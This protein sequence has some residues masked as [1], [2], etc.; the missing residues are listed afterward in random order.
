MKSRE[1]V[2]RAVEFETPGRLPLSFDSLGESDFHT[3]QWNQIGT[4]DNTKRRTYDEWGCGWI[5]TETANMGQVKEH[6]L[7]EWSMLE[8]YSWPDPDSAAFYEGMEERFGGSEAKYITT[9][10]FMLL[11]ERLHSLRGFANTLMD[12]YQE[13]QKV[14]ELAD[15]IVDFDI[16]II[17]NISSRFPG[18][19]Q[20]FKFSDDWGTETDLIIRPDLWREFFKPRYSRIF[21]ACRQAGWHVW[22]HTCGKVNA[23]IADLI[24]SGVDV[25]NLQ[26]PT[27]LGIEEVGE[28]FAGRVCFSSLCDIQKTL[29]FKDREEIRREAALLLRCWS[30]REGGFVLSD[31]GDGDAIGVPIEKKHWMLESFK[32]LDPWKHGGEVSVALS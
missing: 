5:R 1:I 6:P 9:G 18:A 31:Y 2:R 28:D 7:S 17:E 19:I 8:G 20:G 32:E 15:R 25:L 14:E 29:P 11:F 23:I 26:Q 4:G 30:T 13:R 24:E 12:F 10:I 21:G 3:V 16:R 22:M 27:L